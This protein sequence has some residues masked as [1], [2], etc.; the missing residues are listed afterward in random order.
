M[1]SFVDEKDGFHWN[2]VRN[3][4]TDTLYIFSDHFQESKEVCSDGNN[5]GQR[6]KVFH[7]ENG[8]IFY[9]LFIET[10]MKLCYT[11]GK[12]G[13]LSEKKTFEFCHGSESLLNTDKHF[14]LENRK[15]VNEKCLLLWKR[16]SDR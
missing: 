12:D 10:N 4:D 8:S 3:Q 11:I 2:A 5:I 1:N 14:K 16:S 13:S 7:N 6:K 9:G 15:T